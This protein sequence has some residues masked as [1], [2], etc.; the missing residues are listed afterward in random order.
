M[1]ALVHLGCNMQFDHQPVLLNEVVATFTA[2]Q[3][4]VLVDCTLGGAGHSSALLEAM[5]GM[6]LIGLDRDPTA[7]EVARERLAPYGDRV[8]IVQA[9]FSELEQVLADLGV[10]GVDGILADFGVS[11][12]QLDTPGRGFSFRHDGPLDMRMNDGEGETAAELL[13]RI[14]EGELA[15]AIRDYGEERHARR[16]ARAILAADPLPSTTGELAEIIRSVVRPAKDGLDPA[17]RTFQGLRILVNREL[18]EIQRWVAGCIGG[19]NDGGVVAAISFHSLEDRIVKQGFR[20]ATVT[21]VCPP[22]LPQCM[23]NVV[24]TLKV[25]T[26]RPIVPS[27]EEIKDNPRARSSKL[28]VARRLNRESA[29]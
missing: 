26:R 7:I 27:S 20:E 29:K 10:S 6:R 4:K 21:C 23:C 16:V 25:E 2:Q 5:E 11:S 3:P 19:L 18:E 14:D 13:A 17:T 9:R 12:H 22:Q 15:Q 8:T 1:T 24:P 28:R